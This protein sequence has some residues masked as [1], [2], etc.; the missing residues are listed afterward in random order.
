MLS[1]EKRNLIYDSCAA[2]YDNPEDAQIIAEATVIRIEGNT[3]TLSEGTGL[4]QSF[5]NKSE[6]GTEVGTRK[7][8]Q[9][10]EMNIYLGQSAKRKLGGGC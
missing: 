6:S 1:Q 10:S 8:K 3:I 2:V 7:R 5:R 9:L 4:M